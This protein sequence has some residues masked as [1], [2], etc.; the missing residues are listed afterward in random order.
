MS[1]PETII[2]SDDLYLSRGMH[3]WVYYHP[4]NHS[5]CIK[6]PYTPNDIDLSRELRYRKI[7]HSQNKTISLLPK[8]YGEINTNLGKGYIFERIQ[9]YDGIC[10]R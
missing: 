2:L 5:L 4:H 6:I 7:L 10:V 8:Y 1:N 3:K 9:D